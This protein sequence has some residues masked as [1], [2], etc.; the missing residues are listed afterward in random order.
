MTGARLLGARLKLR[1]VEAGDLAAIHA[2]WTE[3]Q[4]RRFLFDDRAL[5]L[6]EAA[7]FV[8]TSQAT[9]EAHGYGVWLAHDAC[10]GRLAGFAGLL[11]AR[12][13]PPS[14]VVGLAPASWGR[15]LALEAA[16]LVLDHAFDALG[17]EELRADVDEPN[18]ASVRLLD[19][20]GFAFEG[21]AADRPLRLYRLSHQ[22]W[23]D[24]RP[25]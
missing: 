16:A 6:D 21:R 23:R 10:E 17:F 5:T 18:V 24:S 11:G 13:D 12:D 15:G 1:P 8:E 22:S 3:P 9:F 19:R 14:L 7:G 2:L 4:V 25:R 20:L